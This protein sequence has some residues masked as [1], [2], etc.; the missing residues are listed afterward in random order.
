MVMKA[1]LFTSPPPSRALAVK[2]SH[3]QK[4]KLDMPCLSKGVAQ[5]PLWPVDAQPV[6]PLLTAHEEPLP[7]PLCL[8]GMITVGDCLIL[9]ASLAIYGKRQVEDVVLFCT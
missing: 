7:L 6:N 1:W 4:R 9:F 2:H 5:P 3:L 8:P